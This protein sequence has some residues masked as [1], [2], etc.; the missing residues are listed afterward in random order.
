MS[1]RP[2]KRVL[3]WQLAA[4]TAV[5]V[6]LSASGTFSYESFFLLSVLAFLIVVDLTKPGAVRPR[7]R[8]RLRWLLAVALVGFALVVTKRL[9]AIS[10]I[11]IS[12]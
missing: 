11:G 1:T 9:F 12:G 3:V 6:G 4:M 8:V 10:A 7:W 2:R 5:V